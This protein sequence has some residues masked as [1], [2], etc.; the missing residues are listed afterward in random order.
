MSCPR[1]HFVERGRS[2]N[3]NDYVS[4]LWRTF[5]VCGIIFGIIYFCCSSLCFYSRLD[6]EHPSMCIPTERADARN[7]AEELNKEAT[8]GVVC[9][10]SG[11]ATVKCMSSSDSNIILSR[12][13]IRGEPGAILSVES[14]EETKGFTILS[15]TLEGRLAS[16]DRGDIYWRI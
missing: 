16:K 6:S 5:L 11:R 7:S 4:S 3:L 15:S 14:I 13:S 1:C 2:E 8:S 10:K 9:L 12:K